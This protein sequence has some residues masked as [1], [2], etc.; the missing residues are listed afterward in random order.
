ML[1]IWSLV[2]IHNASLNIAI[3]LFLHKKL[4]KKLM[5][6]FQKIL[7]VGVFELTIMNIYLI[8]CI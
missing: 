4:L 7:M 5:K 6:I 1:K 2:K 8:S 3:L